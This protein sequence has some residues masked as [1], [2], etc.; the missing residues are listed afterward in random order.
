[1]TALRRPWIAALALALLG[2]L[3][4][5]GADSVRKVGEPF[6]GF[7]VWNNGFLVSFH[8]ADWTG[9]RAGLPLN[10]GRITAFESKPFRD[11]RSV[12]TR[13]REAPLGSPLAFRVL[14]HDGEREFQVETMRLDWVGWGLTFGNYLANAL[15]CFAIAV[16]ALALRPDSLAARALAVAMIALGVVLALAVDLVATY[17]F[18]PAYLI[19]EAL[20]PASVA[21]FALHFP[22]ERLAPRARAIALAVTAALALGM[23]VANAASFYS[24]PE[25]AR[26]LT[27]SAYAATALAA[28]G[29]LASFGHAT[30]R[31]RTA[32][33]RAQAGVVLTGALVSF[34]L[35]SIALLAFSLLDWTFSFTWMTALIFVFPIS[36]L[37]AIVRH[38]LFEAE[39]F[40]RVTLG[41]AVATSGVVLAY[42]TT[43]T[44]VTGYAGPAGADPA[45]SFALLVT[46]AIGFEPLRRATQN[47][48]DRVF[49]RAVANPARVLEENGADLATLLDEAAIRRAVAERAASS[50]SLSGASCDALG[51]IEPA[52]HA[53]PIEFRGEKLGELR[54]GE[55]RSGAPFSATDRE[56]L[57]GLA[58]QAALA[59]QSAR[60]MRGLEAAQAALAR[61]ERLAMIGEFAGAVAHGIRNPLAG[62][63]VAAQIAQEQAGD[64]PAAESLAGIVSEADRLEQR[65]RALLDYARPYEANLRE[66]DLSALLASVVATYERQAGRQGASIRAEVQGD[67]RIVT[68]PDLL[69]EA[70]LELVGNALRLQ[71]SGA[72]VRLRAERT[73]RNLRLRVEDDGPG[74][75]EAIQLRIFELFFTTRREGSGMGLASVRKIAESLGGRALL[76]HSGAQ[77]TVFVIELPLR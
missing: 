32:R 31:G 11:G 13:V 17:R 71:R 52:A 14:D 47:S 69:E 22:R 7:F 9:A 58:S 46:L 74:I 59:L 67:D 51:G 29:M 2:L 18:V 21:A 30:F 43:L 53:E 60:A 49:F 54:V 41:Y 8:S 63:R 55:K 56:L 70:L 73:G 6:P 42:A 48:V 50:L 68:D 66:V 36:V 37:W 34:F 27:S 61:S 62:I 3:G 10:G 57:R 45:A 16:V 44:L 24:H 33:E 40:I 12:Y 39:R 26:S 35:P 20:V 76:E 19:S 77:G 25:L 28:L 38:E 64:G 72:G 4:V 15:F 1:M 75:P 5:V 65:V 23:G